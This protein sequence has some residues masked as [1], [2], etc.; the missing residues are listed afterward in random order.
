MRYRLCRAGGLRF[1]FLTEGQVLGRR[2]LLLEGEFTQ[3]LVAGI[4]L[5]ASAP[6][7][8]YYFLQNLSHFLLQRT[9]AFCGVCAFSGQHLHYQVT[10]YLSSWNKVVS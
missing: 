3:M 1:I 2:T 7:L 9:T 8:V 10:Y 4:T 5:S 6:Q